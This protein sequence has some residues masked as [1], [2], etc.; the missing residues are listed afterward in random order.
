M[1]YL[2]LNI[3]G[4]PIEAPS[5]IPSCGLDS[6]GN[7]IIQTGLMYLIGGAAVFAVIVL[8]L[9]GID[10]ILSSGDKAKIE[11]ARLRITYAIIGLILVLLSFFIVTV[12]G[13]LFGLDSIL[14]FSV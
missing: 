11:K 14:K 6:C 2:T 4:T 7:R 1:D 13:S 5:G 9:S 12:V 3:N 10:W 8:V